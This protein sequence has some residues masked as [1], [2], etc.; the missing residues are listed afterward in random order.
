MQCYMEL[1]DRDTKGKRYDVTPL[2]ADADAFAELVDDLIRQ[3]DGLVFDTVAGID[4]LGFILASALA[5]H[6]KLP[7]VPIRKGGKLPVEVDVETFVDYTGKEKSLEVRND[8]FEN[9]QR[10]LLVDEWVE[11]GAQI[12]TAIAL[13]ERQGA[14]VAGVLAMNISDSERI[15]GLRQR[16]K[17]R[18]VAKI[19]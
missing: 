12:G 7:L 8:A 2:F 11:T 1:I 9:A 15:R 14:A 6:L 19:E 13:I 16:Y 4:A 3:S 5:I 17:L 10:V 18:A